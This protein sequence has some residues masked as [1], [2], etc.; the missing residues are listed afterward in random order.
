[1]AKRVPVTKFP[2][3]ATVNYSRALE[4]MI[5][6]L[7][8]ETLAL[9][10]KYVAPEMTTRQDA[11][12]TEDGASDG[13]IKMLHSLKSKGNKIFNVSLIEQVASSF[14][15]NVNRFN[16]NNI[17]QQMKV[18]GI[19]LVATEPW[20]KDFLHTNISNNVGFIQ[21][22]HDDYFTRIENIIYNG[23]KG[24]TS[25]KH[26]REQLMKEV[27]ISK[28]RAQFIAVDQAGTILGQ[29]TARRHQNLGIERFTWDT[30]GDE[31]V[32][33]T[34]RELDGKVFSYDDPP[35][36][37]GR[38]VLPGEDYRC[39]CVPLPVF[40]DDE[41]EL[42]EPTEE[43]QEPESIEEI[44]HQIAEIEKEMEKLENEEFGD[45]SE[46]E[47][48]ELYEELQSKLEALREKSANS[49]AP[50]YNNG[51]EVF[52]G[53]EGNIKEFFLEDTNYIS[54][55]NALTEDDVDIIN[56]YTDTDYRS[57]N[58][59]MRNGE[60]SFRNN[61]KYKGTS[62]SWRDEMVVNAKKLES[63]LSGYVVEK[64][65][66]TYRETVGQLDLSDFVIGSEKV[67][68]DGFMSTSLMEEVT[69]GFG[70]AD[71]N[72]ILKIKVNKGAEV[73]GYIEEFSDFEEEREFLFKPKTKFKVTSVRSEK[74][75]HGENQY[76]ELEAD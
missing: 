53:N 33:D 12:L 57:L 28:S 71:N 26:M 34:H 62:E 23:V 2:D 70:G 52:N 24:G 44:N 17:Q 30:S 32:R 55:K 56:R 14:V 46:S 20:L 7:G 27:E 51:E 50:N 6:S 45:L 65:F 47:A 18:K 15:K 72:I 58:E 75:E 19:D 16:R 10:N 42:I 11:Q 69:K 1:M 13:L 74:T 64:P 59:I 31:R 9:F 37:N 60:D 8:K 36:I 67:I 48:E 5:E 61:P 68:D 39:R 29:M 66:M 73:G 38:I 3:G 76:I 40:D 63:V 22:I 41:E 49:T 54:W 43:I 35:T 4:K 25:I 21:S